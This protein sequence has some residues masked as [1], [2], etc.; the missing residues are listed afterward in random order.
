MASGEFSGAPYISSLGGHIPHCRNFRAVNEAAEVHSAKVISRRQVCSLFAKTGMASVLTTLPLCDL[1]QGST[2]SITGKDVPALRDFDTLLLDYLKRNKSIPGASLAMSRDGRIIYARGFGCADLDTREAVEPDSL[3]RIASVSKTFTSAAIMVLVQRGRLKLSDPAF[4]LLDI[5]VPLDKKSQMDTRLNTITIH[6]LLCHT[7]GWAR[8]S[9][10]NPFETWTGFD[11]M[12]FP[13]EIAQSLGVPSPAGPAEIVRFMTT[14]PL[15]FDPGTRYAYSNFGYC[16]LGRV[17]EKVSGVSYGEF[18]RTELLQPLG[19]QDA[20][21]GK[22]LLSGR[23]AQEV[24]YYPSGDKRPNSRNVF[25]GPDVQWCYGGFELEAMDSHGGWI[26]T[27]SDLVRFAASL[28]VP[29]RLGPLDAESIQRMFERPAETG[30]AANGVE[31][32]DYY[33]YGWHVQSTVP[34]GREEWHDGLFGGTS[35]L[36]MRRRDGIVWALTFNTENDDNKQVPSE[37]LAPRINQLAD[38]IRRWPASQPAR[39]E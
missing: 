4:L 33:A 5:H 39:C 14:R 15:D 9:A 12:F 31:L 8:G 13:V 23:A 16:V 11:P 26:A 20:R 2:T 10:K 25:G 7:G 17:I 32:S 18:V 34:E 35:A 29:T 37:A 28:E 22:S 21:L 3:F 1:A 6:H 30:Y 36:V 24:H 19:I 27:P 38:S